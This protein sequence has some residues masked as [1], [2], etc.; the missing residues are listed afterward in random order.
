MRYNLEGMTDEEKAVRLAEIRA[1]NKKLKAIWDAKTRGEIVESQSADR[2]EQMDQFATEID[3][4]VTYLKKQRGE[5][6]GKKN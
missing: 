2:Y 3:E 5:S 4:L 1:E 6:D